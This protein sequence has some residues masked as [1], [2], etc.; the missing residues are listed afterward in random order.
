MAGT[1]IRALRRDRRAV[2]ALEYGIIAAMLAFVLIAIFQH[3]GNTLL[4][5]GAQIFAVL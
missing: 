5:I 4:V 1:I 3:L 2:T